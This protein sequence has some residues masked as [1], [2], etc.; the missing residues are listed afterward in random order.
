VK[1][2]IVGG[3]GR[4]HAIAWKLKRDDPS[5][6]LHCAPGNPGIASLA[7]C[8]A[9]PATDLDGLVRL[10]LWERFDFTI[11]GPEAPLAAGLVDRLTSRG[12]PAFG[13]TAAAAHI[14]SSKRFAKEIM[15]RAG[16]PTARATWHTTVD[17]ARAAVRQ[18]GA[19]VVIKAS[20]LASGKGV[21]VCQTTEAADQAIDELLVSHRFGT[22]GDEILVEEYM[23]G[24]ELSIFF[25]TD[26]TNARAMIA[27]QDHKRL[28]DGDEGPNTGGMGA[29]AP[30]SLASHDLMRR[31]QTTIVEPTLGA[32]RDV[33]VPF[34]GLLYCGLMLTETG[35]RVV[36]FNCRFGDPETQVVLPLLRSALLPYLMACR[37]ENGLA[38]LGE[39][40]FE[41]EA[42][43]TTVVAAAGYPESP[44]AGDPIDLS[45]VPDDV[46]VFHAGTTRTDEGQLCTS[47]GRVFAV[48]GVAASFADAQEKSRYGAE[49][50][51]FADRVL[52]RD[53]GWRENSRRAGVT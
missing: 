11:V 39:L 30:V 46:I 27:A 25:L 23:E 9:T 2:L 22:S 1:V 31:V 5:L 52:R 21:M 36:E 6:D 40:E 53:I 17:S 34:Q 42:A 47:G 24:E 51:K 33:G 16:V 7:T 14:E 43:V 19:P 35:P 12:F 13:P 28:Q 44:R 26:G 48:T 8:H 20:G 29:Y 45:S 18:T 49:Q 15:Q 4:E 50:V 37:V 3:G 10:A 41:P 38:G 32:M